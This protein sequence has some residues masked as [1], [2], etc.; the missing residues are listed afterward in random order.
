LRHI[1]FAE[2]IDV[3]PVKFEVIMEWL[4]SMNVQEVCSFMGLAG[5]YRRFFE[6]FSK[7]ANPIT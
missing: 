4:A 1:I 7:I 3:D 5:Y 2:G 6:V